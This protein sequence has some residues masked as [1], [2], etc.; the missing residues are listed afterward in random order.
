MER[1]RSMLARFHRSLF[2]I[3]FSAILIVPALAQVTT[4]KTVQG[5]VLDPNRAAI[6]GADVW[7]GAAGLPSASAVTDRNGEFSVML[8]PGEYQVRIMAE[9]FSEV[10]QTVN[11]RDSLNPKPLE[12]VLS[13]GPSNA[14]VT[15]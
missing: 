15:I 14:T 9:G 5:K 7:I 13:V 2:L 10:T 6:Q 1:S 11:L 12:I 8:E 3:L 4:K